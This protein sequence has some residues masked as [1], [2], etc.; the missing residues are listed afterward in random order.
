MMKRRTAAA[1]LDLSIAELEREIVSGR[2]PHP[3]ML[4]NSLHWSRAEIDA[5]VERL[6]GVE[7]GA[8]DWRSKTKLYQTR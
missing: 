7:S 5:Y 6:T 3:V 8:D 1:Y 2:L 4:G